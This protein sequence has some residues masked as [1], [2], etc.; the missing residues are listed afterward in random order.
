MSGGEDNK[1]KSEE[2]TQ[3][4]L[5]DARKKGQVAKSKEVVSAAMLVTMFLFLGATTDFYAEHFSKLITAA[6]DVLNRPFTQALVAM[7]EVTTREFLLMSLPMFVIVVPVAILSNFL[8][9]GP[10]MAFEPLKPEYSKIDPV[11]NM[12]NMFSIKSMVELL[13]SVIKTLVLSFVLY[14][15]VR[16]AIADLVRVPDCG[17]ECIIPLVKVISWK[18]FFFTAIAFVVVAALDFLFQKKQFLKSM[19]MTMDEVKREY[20]EQE[21]DPEIKHKRKEF[22]R[23]IIN[24]EPRQA[25]RDSTVL[26]TNPEHLAIGLFYKEDVTP[27][28]LISIKA[29]GPDAQRAKAYA[30]EFEIPMMENVPLAHALMNSGNVQEYIPSDLIEPVAE[31]IRWAL[32]Q[33]PE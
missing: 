3:K 24:E 23:E 13:K 19:R 7:A 6:I 31:I 5:E 25:V 14:T 2:P 30:R 8:Q 17:M 29:K 4:R 33:K 26:V 22:H 18:I 20:K 21:G 12:K 11:K 15:A 32:E 10:V 9:T 28:P 16:D 1:D 27:L